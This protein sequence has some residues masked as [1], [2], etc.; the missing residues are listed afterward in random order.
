MTEPGP[1]RSTRAP[2]VAVGTVIVTIVGIGAFAWFRIWQARAGDPLVWQDSLQYQSLGDQPLF[3]HSI[4]A[5]DRPPVTPLFWK[6]AGNASTFVFLQTLVSVAAWSVLAVVVARLV[7]PR[8]RQ[9]LAGGVVLGFAA[10]RP[11]T[12]WDRSILSESFSLSALAL[13]F[14]CTILWARHPTIT[15]AAALIGAALLFAATRDT[16]IWIVALVAVA[17]GAYALRRARRVDPAAA[18][19]ALIVAAGLVLVVVCTATSSMVSHRHLTNVQN[20]LAVRV[21]PYPNRIGWFADHGMPQ[22]AAVTALARATAST[23][24][25]APLVA[26]DLG[27]PAFRPLAR[28]LRTDAARTYITWLAL[29]PGTVLKDPLLR[30]ERTYNNADGHLSNYAAAD[31]SDAPLLTA[32]LYPAWPWVLAAAVAAVIGGW[33]LGQVRRLAW[34]AVALLGVLGFAHMLIAWHGDGMEVTRHASVGNVQVRLGVL[35]LL[36]MLLDG[37]RIPRTKPDQPAVSINPK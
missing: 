25:N 6:L 12:Q 33:L 37:R 11:I 19:P 16:Q 1:A 36:L 2:A 10:S 28:W 32:L 35:I 15:R 30:P 31:R 4:W 21:F 17:F 3:S 5:G 8:G 24:G 18:R 26:I 7:R 34:V 14:A 9:L 22:A 29:H 20:A 13:L 27:D 23:D